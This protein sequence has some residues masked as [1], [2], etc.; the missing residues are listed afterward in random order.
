MLGRRAVG[1]DAQLVRR[2][3]QRRVAADEMILL[4]ATDKRR[5]RLKAAWNR[6]RT[7][8]L[9]TQVSHPAARATNE[10]LPTDLS[11]VVNDV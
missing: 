8:R 6:K 11:T 1:T 7:E 2:V 4:I 10:R 9:S 3:L 5:G